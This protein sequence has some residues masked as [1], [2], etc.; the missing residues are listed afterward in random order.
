MADLD[1]ALSR[2]LGWLLLAT[3]F[4]A[5]G[6][7][8]PAAER[9][10]RDREVGRADPGSAA[11]EV[12]RGLASVQ[13]AEDGALDLWAQAPVLTV[14]F[15]TDEEAPATWEITLQN[16][17]PEAELVASSDGGEQVDVVERRALAATTISWTVEL[18][19]GA[20]TSLHIAPPDAD[21]PEE[22]R[23]A[24][25]SDIQDDIG[26]VDDIFER[27]NRDEEIRFVVS[28][29]DLTQNGTLRELTNFRQSL[30]ELDVPYFTTIG[31]HELGES[32]D[33][34]FHEFFGRVNF[35]F[36]F[37]ETAFTFLDS[38]SAT[39]DPVAYEW[40]EV[41][42]ERADDDLHVFL[43]HIPPIDPIGTRNGSFRSRNE[44]QKLLNMLTRGSVDLAL[45]GH[46]HSYYAEKQ[47][48]IPMFISGG[49]GAL[50]EKFD[51]IDRHYLTVDITPGER[52]EQVGF[53]QIDSG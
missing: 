31:N 46:L 9:V 13:T 34:G 6:C 22:Y 47:A 2:P 3:L 30:D 36:D 40:L 20:S 1:V 10:E 7:L 37:K 33:G 17:M 53:V 41:W 50:P 48:D 42:L 16:A 44:A 43:T 4:A 52:I 23:F 26:R 12:D 45:Y 19:A 25:L 27:I 8:E 49:G 39:I 11:I 21:D 5:A 28:T 29:G 14:D 35:Q 38:A 18:P 51:G 15:E 32:A 24:L